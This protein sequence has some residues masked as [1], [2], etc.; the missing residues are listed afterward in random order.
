MCSKEDISKSSALQQNTGTSICESA[1]DGKEDLPRVLHFWMCAAEELQ[2]TKKG[3]VFY[4]LSL[5][6]IGHS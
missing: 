1:L 3:D 6:R 2:I 5:F 4:V